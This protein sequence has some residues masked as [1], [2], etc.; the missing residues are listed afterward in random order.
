MHSAKERPSKLFDTKILYDQVV[1]PSTDF[2]NS[3]EP[4]G[5]APYYFF[6]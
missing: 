1:H 6:Y 4:T 3:L 5:A 2:L